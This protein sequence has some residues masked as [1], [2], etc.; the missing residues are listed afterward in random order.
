MNLLFWKH[1]TNGHVV[2]DEDLKKLPLAHQA[3]FEATKQQPTHQVI[4]K[5]T[6][7]H[8]RSTTFIDEDNSDFLLSALVGYE[9]GS[10]L[11]GALV[12]GDI[13][14]AALGDMLS[15]D[16]QQPT[17]QDEPVQM[18]GGD[19][20]GGGS[21]GD[22]GSNQQDNEQPADD[23]QQSDPEPEQ[24]DNTDYSSNDTNDYSSNGDN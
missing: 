13:A 6:V 12:G 1:K 10:T 9:T 21:S 20:G 5:N 18:S 4:T 16:D 15:Q 7:I 22:W 19:F 14:G 8:N 11:D 23:Y 24:Q 3:H 2:A 17:Q